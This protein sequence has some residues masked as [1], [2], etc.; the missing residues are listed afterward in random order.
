[1][2]SVADIDTLPPPSPHSIK[3]GEEAMVQMV[4]CLYDET[5]ADGC[6][7]VAKLSAT[8]KSSQRSMAQSSTIMKAL[9]DVVE[10]TLSFITLSNAALALCE[11]T[12]VPD[13]HVTFVSCKPDALQSLV[14]RCA[15]LVPD[16]P[17]NDYELL[18]FRRYWYAGLFLCCTHTHSALFM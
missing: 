6:H 18:C 7:T 13:G 12:A 8:Y 2:T 15:V 14:H 3:A 16:V 10:G 17:E 11:L 5:A 4:S 9:L 1:M